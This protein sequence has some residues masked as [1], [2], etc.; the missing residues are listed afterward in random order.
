ML[1]VS[2]TRLNCVAF[3]CPAGS[4]DVGIYDARMF[5]A[6]VAMFVLRTFLVCADRSSTLHKK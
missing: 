2:D 5:T 1:T 6:G 4:D 3:F